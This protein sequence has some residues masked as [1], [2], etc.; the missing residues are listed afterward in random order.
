MNATRIYAA[1]VAGALLIAGVIYATT[2]SASAPYCATH[3]DGMGTNAMNQC[4]TD[5]GNWCEK[6]HPDDALCMN[7]VY[8]YVPSDY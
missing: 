7:K 8:R 2:A 1:V 4:L 3:Q 6:H 5:V